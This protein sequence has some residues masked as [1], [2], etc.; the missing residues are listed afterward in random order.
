[1]R[2][3]ADGRRRYLDVEW[4]RARDGRRVVVEVD[5]RGHMRED[6]WEDDLLKADD[7]TI[8]DHAIVLRL[9][10]TTARTR[11]ERVVAQLRRV[12]L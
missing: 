1:M 4:V 6:V 11:P 2:R 7:V 3:D 5:G 9:A 12:L 8:D 10:G